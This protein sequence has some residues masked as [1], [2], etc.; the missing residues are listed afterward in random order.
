M[1][2]RTINKDLSRLGQS[3]EA[4]INGLMAVQKSPAEAAARSARVVAIPLSQIL[5]DRFQTRVILPPELKQAF[6]SGEAD[7][8]ATGQALLVAAD[9]DNALRRQVDDLL[10]LGASIL[11]E[12]QIEPATGSW[13]QTPR[14][15]R[16]LLEAGERRFWALVLT[17]VQSGREQ[18]PRLQVVEQKETSRFRQ[19]AENLQR[20]DIS[21]VDLAKAVAALILL[22]MN[23]PPDANL[24]ELEYYRQALQIKRLPSGTWPDIER[25]VGLSRPYLYRHLQILNLDDH[26]LYL[27][28]LYRLEER[29][30]REIV[31]APR[32]RQRSLLLA[33]VEE[34]LTQADLA[35]AAEAPLSS[36]AGTHP[37]T[38]PGPHRQLASRVKGIL[39]FVRGADFDQNFDEVASELSTL[40]RDPE[41]LQAAAEALE[42]LAASLRKIRARR[43]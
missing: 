29:R 16:F 42:T 17:A 23:M 43:S 18:E 40:L 1:P 15:A 11:A 13:V 37:H 14:G 4:Q 9:G 5:P 41:D 2:K 38:A 19:V 33:A 31:A 21:A 3:E 27:A 28:S 6:I 8:Y 35:R 32:E 10:A 7:C 24:D 20:E 39:K 36:E 26:L 12:G 34:Q 25:V 30:L 22:L